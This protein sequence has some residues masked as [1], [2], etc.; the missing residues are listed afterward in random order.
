M[1]KTYTITFTV[2]VHYPNVNK[3]LKKMSKDFDNWIKEWATKCDG[4]EQIMPTLYEPNKKYGDIA[5]DPSGKVRVKVVRDG[6]VIL[7]TSWE[8]LANDF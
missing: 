5:H 7:K 2:D 4:A 6:E 1:K 8:E 3:H